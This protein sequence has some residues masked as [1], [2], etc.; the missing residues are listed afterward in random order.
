MFLALLCVFFVF[1]DFCEKWSMY[2]S[3]D[4][5][6]LITRWAFKLFYSVLPFWP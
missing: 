3:Y 2:L 6:N 1:K 5:N 4:L